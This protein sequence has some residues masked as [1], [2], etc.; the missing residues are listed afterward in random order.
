MLVCCRI[1][2][3]TD[4]LAHSTTLLLVVSSTSRLQEHLPT[5]VTNIHFGP[6]HP[7]FSYWACAA[8]YIISTCALLLL[9]AF[10]SSSYFK[11]RTKI[12]LAMRFMRLLFQTA[13]LVTPSAAFN[14]A[15]AVVSR[16]SKNPAKAPAMLVIHPMVFYAQSA[17]M[18]L[19]WIHVAPIQLMSTTSLLVYM[20]QFPCFLQVS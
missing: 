13:T 16:V 1:L 3:N 20:W 12:C 5:D 17:L 14:I 2:F 18:L 7:L 6:R 4:V 11:H 8:L 10:R 9:L 19:P 15:S